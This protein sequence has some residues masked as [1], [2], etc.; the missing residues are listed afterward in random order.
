[1]PPHAQR[2]AIQYA[3]RQRSA[4]LRGALPLRF[5]FIP[6]V[7]RTITFASMAKDDRD[8]VP[9]WDGSVA[10]W[11]DI[12]TDVELYVCGATATD[13]YLPVLLAVSPAGRALPCW[14]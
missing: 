3:H 11:E 5:C 10:T 13:R 8:P 2:L 12:D 4:A 14:A 9:T 1:M 7:G 6:T